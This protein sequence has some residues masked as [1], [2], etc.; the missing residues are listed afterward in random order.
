MYI[1]SREPSTI[2]I[3][4]EREI[5]GEREHVLMVLC[6]V[7]ISMPQSKSSFTGIEGTGQQS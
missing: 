6:F 5:T 3:E 1:Y 7:H 2:T 4:N